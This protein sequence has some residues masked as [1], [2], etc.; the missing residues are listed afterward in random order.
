MVRC[1]QVEVI[2]ITYARVKELSDKVFVSRKN[3]LTILT[4]IK[5][6]GT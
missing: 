1:G 6:S 3:N 2:L 5:N 4:K